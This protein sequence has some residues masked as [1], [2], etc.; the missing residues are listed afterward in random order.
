[1]RKHDWMKFLKHSNWEMFSHNS[2]LNKHEIS[3][4]MFECH[5]TANVEQRDYLKQS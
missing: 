1:M 2:Y 4:N 5:V 3:D